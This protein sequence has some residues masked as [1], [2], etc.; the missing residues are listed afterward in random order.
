VDPETFDI[1][2]LKYLVVH[3]CG[4]VINPLVVHGFV[5]GG[6]AHGIGGAM[7]ELFDY[8][9]QGQL[10]SASFM[11]YL[12]PTVAEIPHVELHEMSTP[13]PLHP[14]GAKGAAEGPYLTT[15]A[16]IA[17][18]VEDALSPLGLEVNRVPITPDLLFRLTRAAASPT[19]AAS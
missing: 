13:S 2:F 14:Y 9:D 12:I 16:A 6:I 4:T 1:K 3:D 17:S 10:M 15:P 11:D 5:Y 7:Y 19:V 8:D 18:A